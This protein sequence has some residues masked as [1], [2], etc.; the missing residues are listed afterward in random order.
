MLKCCRWLPLLCVLPLFAAP[1]TSELR[2]VK[3]DTRASTIV[4]SLKASGLPSLDGPWHWI[5]PFDNPDEHPDR[6]PPPEKEIDLAKT[7]NGRDGDS[8][9]WRPFKN[10]KLG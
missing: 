7:Y 4:A 5:G 6:V 3:K 8:V 10:F 1:Q 2:Y 9:A